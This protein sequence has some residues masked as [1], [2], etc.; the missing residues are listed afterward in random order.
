MRNVVRSVKVGF[1]RRGS[2][3]T[4]R[5]E[6]ETSSDLE[7]QSQHQAT[8]NQRFEKRISQSARYQAEVHEEK[9]PLKF[10]TTKAV[11]LHHVEEP[12]N[13]HQPHSNMSNSTMPSSFSQ[14]K[15]YNTTAV[16]HSDVG[17]SSLNEIATTSKWSTRKKVLVG[18]M[19]GVSIAAV[20]TVTIVL[21]ILLTKSTG[22]TSTTTASSVVVSAYWTFDTTVVDSYGVYN[23]QLVNGTL[24]T[25]ASATN[26]P[27]V[28]V[29]QALDLTATLFN[30]F[31]VSSPFFDLSNTSFTI[32]AWIYIKASSS[33]RGIFGQCSCST[34]AY[35][36]LYLIIRN[37]RL[38]IDFTSNHLSGSTILYNSTWY[39]I[40]FVY[41]YGTQQQILYVNGVV[42]AIKSN[43]QPYQGQNGSITIGSK[44]KSSTGI[45]SDASLA[46]YY[47]F[48]SPSTSADSGPNGVGG[49]AI[50]TRS[51]TGRVNQGM[52]FYPSISSYFRAYGFYQIPYGVVTNQPFSL[53]LW[54]NPSSTSSSTLIQSF[55]AS[56]GSCRTILGFYS[57][58]T[59]GG[60]IFALC[61][62]ASPLGLTGP[63]ITQNTWTHV[64]L[65]Y[66][67]NNGYTLY[68]NGVFFGST[69][70]VLSVTSGT[71]A[72]LFIGYYAACCSGTFSYNYQ[73]S[74]DEL[75]VYNR[76]L[77]QSEVAILANP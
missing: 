33:D 65:T 63:F 5:N 37:N 30:S 48:D 22:S 18:S 32:E 64:S 39:H 52:Y 4:G 8:N 11:R 16:E 25:S 74:I 57:Y 66:S 67:L 42:D 1:I 62:G 47:S 72:H 61:N 46:A 69:G 68:V 38:Y 17:K 54:I 21:S 15:N 10:G 9:P 43:A 36:C 23:G 40:A 27:Y 50:N 75:Y 70:F 26:M 31:M 14:Q 35:Q 19:V 45:L 20:I 51:V 13:G 49:S 76:E 58:G 3:P 12:N 28:G 34:C 44:A 59:S 41:N 71:L 73:G 2:I 24:Y 56:Y 77:A 60:Q 29:G 6:S 7:L 53:A 55:S